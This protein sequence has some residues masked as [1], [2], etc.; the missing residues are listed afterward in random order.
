MEPDGSLLFCSHRVPPL[1]PI[2]SQRIRPSPRPCV[3]FR[4][5][6]CVCVRARVFCGEQLLACRQT[7]KLEDLPSRLSA[8]ACSIYSQLPSMPEGHLFHPKPEN[9]SCNHDKDP[10]RVFQRRGS[11]NTVMN[12]RVP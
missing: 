3:T 5:L 4:N 12:L 10:L 2:L 9:A 8:T 6:M 11:V 1:A 7:R